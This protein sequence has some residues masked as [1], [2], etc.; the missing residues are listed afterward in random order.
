MDAEW[1]IRY[2]TQIHP[3]L[4]G[5]IIG[6]VIGYGVVMASRL[7]QLLSL[8]IDREPVE[9]TVSF[10]TLPDPFPLFSGVSVLGW[11]PWIALGIALVA[12]SA[13][14]GFLIGLNQDLG[15][16]IYALIQGRSP[17]LARLLFRR[18]LGK[19]LAGA[20]ISTRGLIKR[21]ALGPLFMFYVMML[22]CALFLLL[23]SLVARL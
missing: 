14:I 11:N 3:A 19:G 20:D 1:S 9:W 7:L 4:K 6:Y 2:W 5:G 10:I 17:Y 13:L 15:H 18:E 16:H 8:V 22:I 23:F 12:G 21:I